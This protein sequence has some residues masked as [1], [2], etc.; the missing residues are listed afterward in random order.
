MV[1][2]ELTR[3]IKAAIQNSD[4]PELEA[5]YIIME[6]ADMTRE[7][8]IIS[9]RAPLDGRIIEKA[10]A[11]AA[12]RAAG[13]PLAYILGYAEFMGLRF[14]VDP[15]TLIPRQDTE[16]LVERAAELIGSADARVL[17]IGCGSGC[18]GISIAHF[19]R[20]AEVTLL[21]VSADALRTAEENAEKNGVCAKFARCDILSEMPEGEYDMIVS[22]PPYIETDA[23]SGLQ[24][25]IKDYEPKIALDGGKDGLMFY[26]RIAQIG[27]KLLRSGGMLVLEIGCRQADS[28]AEIMSDYKEIRCKNDL[29]GNNRVLSGIKK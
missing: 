2:A 12:R 11:M 19:C 6:A 10:R 17:D 4:A 22:N 13:E 21:D 26:R 20:G 9:K 18:V 3:E 5:D 8:Y 1:I 23:I 29:C 15:S 16:T 25:E 7:E 27:D 28:V 24:T 14:K